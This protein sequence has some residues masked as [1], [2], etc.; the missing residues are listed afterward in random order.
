MH[1]HKLNLKSGMVSGIVKV[2]LLK[3]LPV[4]NIDLLLGNDLAGGQVF[5]EENLVV[6]SEESRMDSKPDGSCIV[7]SSIVKKTEVEN[8]DVIQDSLNQ[9]LSFEDVSESFYR[10]CLKKMRGVRL[11]LEICRCLGKR[12]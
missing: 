11:I 10:L 9:D 2:G 8:K 4:K 3:K 6:K 1:L 7:T 5:P 12:R